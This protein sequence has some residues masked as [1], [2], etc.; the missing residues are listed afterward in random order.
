MMKLLKLVDQI[1]KCFEN[2]ELMKQENI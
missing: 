2:K 1:E